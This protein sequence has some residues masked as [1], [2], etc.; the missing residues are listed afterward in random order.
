MPAWNFETNGLSLVRLINAENMVT[1]SEIINLVK[2]L[3][4]SERLALVETILKDIREDKEL[5]AETQSPQGVSSE[6]GIM[7]LAG[8][9]TE[10][11]A[12]VFYGALKESRKIVN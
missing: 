5:L 12:E 9:M 11:E 10:E 7:S 2:G 4:L 8:I 1:H 6:P 3:S